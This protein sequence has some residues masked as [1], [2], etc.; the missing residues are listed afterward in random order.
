MKDILKFCGLIAAAL[1][2]WLI[3]NQDWTGI[4]Q[5]IWWRQ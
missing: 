1:A 2:L 3:F 4:G 5:P